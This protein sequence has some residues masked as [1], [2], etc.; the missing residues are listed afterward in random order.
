MTYDDR[1]ILARFHQ[2]QGLRYPLLQ[3]V[4]LKHVDAFGVRNQDYEPG[5]SGYGVPYPGV[6]YIGVD[7]KII[8]KFAVPGYRQRP[9]FDRMLDTV[10]G[11]GTAE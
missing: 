3:D 8:A 4:D 10:T 5:D 9:P 2:E 6:L 7:G 11:A 1:A